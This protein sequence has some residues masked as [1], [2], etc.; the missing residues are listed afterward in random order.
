M[1]RKKWKEFLEDHSIS[2]H[3]RMMYRRDCFEAAYIYWIVL[4]A[5][6]HFGVFITSLVLTT[7]ITPWFLFLLL[8]PGLFA[9]PHYVLIKNILMKHYNIKYWNEI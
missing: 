9:W 3:Q 1:T 8:E 6:L 2:Y 5:L 4:W 7:K